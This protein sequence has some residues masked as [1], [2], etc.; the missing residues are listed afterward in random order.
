MI[1]GELKQKLDKFIQKY[2]LNK[3]LRGSI[4]FLGFGLLY[5]FLISLFEYFGH[6]NQKVRLALLVALVGGLGINLVFNILLPLAGLFRMGKHLTYEQAAK[7]I[8]KFFPEIDD[9]IVNTLELGNISEGESSLVKASIEQRISSFR[10]LIFSKAINFRESLKYWPIL[11]V[12]VV[13]FVFV[14]LTGNWK[15]ISESSNRIVSFNEDFIAKAPFRF[16][17]LNKNLDAEEGETYTVEVAFEGSIIPES[18]EFITSNS[19]GRL[20]RNEE[21]IFTYSIEGIKENLKF[22][23]QA[24][25]FSSEEYEIEVIPVPRIK[26]FLIEVVP[27]KYTG[28][29]PFFESKSIQDIPEGSKVHWD[30]KTTS[31]DSAK[32]VS[33]DSSFSFDNIGDGVF[34]LDRVLLKSLEY[35]IVSKNQRIERESGGNNRIN[36]IKDQY[37]EIAVKVDMDSLV[38]NLV[39][40]RAFAA[41]DYGFSKLIMV[42]K[43]GDKVLRQEN[44]QISNFNADAQELAGVFDLNEVSNIESKVSLSFQLWDNDGVNGPKMSRSKTFD[45]KL[46]DDK[47]RKQKIEEQYESY[48][49]N[50]EELNKANDEIL[51]ELERLRQKLMNQKKSSWKDKERVEQLLEKQKAIEKKRQELNKKREE[52]QKK[53][54]EPK[55]EN[56]DLKKKEEQIEKIKEDPKQKELQKLLEEVSKLMEKFDLEKLTEK[57]EEIQKASEE[58]QRKEERLDELMKDLKFKK[59]VLKTAEKLEELAEKMEELSEKEDE[60]GSEQEEQDKVEEE[61]EEVKKELEKLEEENED[62]KKENEDKKMEESEEDVKEEMKKSSEEMEKSEQKKANENQKKAAEKMQEMSQKMMQSMMQMEGEKLEEDMKTLRQ[63]L[64]NLEILSFDVEKLSELSKLSKKSDPL[65]RKLLRDQKH[66]MDGVKIIEDSLVALGKR[67]PAIEEMVYEE[68]EAI[69]ENLDAS[70]SHLQERQGAQSAGKQQFAM[71]AANNL[72]LFLDRALR[73]MQAQ[74]QS[75]QQGSGS[76]TKP[77]SGKPS[78]SNMKKLQNE[79]GKK[80]GKNMKGKKKGKGKPG[81]SG[82]P[83]GRGGKEIVEMLSRQEQIR[84][85]LEDYKKNL[86]EAGEG[87]NGDLAKAIEEME[88]IEDDLLNNNLSLETLERVK[89]IESKLLEFEKAEQERE[90]DEKRESK[91]SDDLEQLY[92]KE[93][94][95]YLREKLKEYESIIYA[96]L[97][98]KKYY[99]KQSNQYLNRF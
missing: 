75:Q 2:Y 15:L 51:E 14:A 61:F 18:A 53:E 31:A 26:S 87:G 73:N 19:N 94:E 33:S 42:L 96:P 72:A 8:G 52:L 17:I 39:Y 28:Q 95:E 32:L 88:K 41:D 49:S 38:E 79:L 24:N 68:L 98:L 81:E 83:E 90:Q 97:N 7:L 71:T 85:Q 34:G 35:K 57:M 64:E 45:I 40:Y 46:L 78:P 70:I 91:S 23:I 65:Y 76:C 58:N 92:K 47:Q 1:Q 5:F 4:Y 6:F 13:I 10:P 48:F 56:E 3:L 22:R 37:P 29:A 12:P 50:K 63:I 60:D 93:R 44:I 55:V 82:K 11:V 80:M 59:D 16:V 84:G 21:G 25:G 36:I 9:K 27:P 66:L 89:E 43:S 86:E 99:Q 30:L 20:T 62:F 69:N 77:G 54:K 74:A 67:V